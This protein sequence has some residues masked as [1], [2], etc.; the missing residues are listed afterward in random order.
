MSIDVY[1][2]TGCEYCAALESGISSAGL[3]SSVTIHMDQGNGG[4]GSA[5]PSTIINGTCHGY[6]SC[7]INC[8]F[9][10]IQAAVSGGATTATPA[11]P[12]T[13]TTATPKATSAAVDPNPA[14]KETRWS[15]ELTI[16]WGAKNP[17]P[18]V[19]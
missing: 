17:M 6:P 16:D 8:Q 2:I 11:K 9:A 12:A 13:T 14:W 15:N 18:T 19:D 3:S 5:N 10:A 7:D 4:C 1:A